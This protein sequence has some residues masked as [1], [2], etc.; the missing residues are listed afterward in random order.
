MFAQTFHTVIEIKCVY[1][2]NLKDFKQAS[3]RMEGFIRVR[4]IRM[5]DRMMIDRMIYD[6]SIKCDRI[7]K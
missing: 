1:W 5:R 6:S 4:D 3:I 7:L 2:V